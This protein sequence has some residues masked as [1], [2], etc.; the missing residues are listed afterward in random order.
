MTIIFIINLHANNYRLVIRE[1]SDGIGKNVYTRLPLSFT[2]NMHGKI[3]VAL[4]RKV[5]AKN[6]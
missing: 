3:V 2:D 6:K 5:F 1:S 4:E